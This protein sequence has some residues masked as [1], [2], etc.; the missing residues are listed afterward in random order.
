MWPGQATSY[1]W[2]SVFSSIRWKYL[3]HYKKDLMRECR[4]RSQ[5]KVNISKCLL[6]WLGPFYLSSVVFVKENIL[7]R[8]KKQNSSGVLLHPSRAQKW[9]LNHLWEIPEAMRILHKSHCPGPW[10]LQ[11]A[12]RITAEADMDCWGWKGNEAQQ[13]APSEPH[14]SNSPGSQ[15]PMAHIQSWWHIL[16][17]RESLSQ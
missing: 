10:P 15:P 16:K 9:P 4:S 12:C 14:N 17:A 11:R 5:H 8:D 7:I 2:V 1:H 3:H 13:W 6:L